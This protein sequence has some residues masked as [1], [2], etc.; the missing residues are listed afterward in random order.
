MSLEGVPKATCKPAARPDRLGARDPGPSKPR[1]ASRSPIVPLMA[2]PTLVD[3]PT[4]TQT[5]SQTGS[6]LTLEHL[7]SAFLFQSVLPS[8]RVESPTPCSPLDCS[9]DRP[10]DVP[11]AWGPAL[12]RDLAQSSVVNISKSFV[13][14]DRPPPCSHLA[15]GAP[16]RVSV[17]LG[18]PFLSPGSPQGRLPSFLHEVLRNR[19][20]PG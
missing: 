14:V 9:P 1:P 15:T 2:D 20:S 13:I 5:S 12:R 6:V 16:Q 3:S 8:R 10:K 7:I 18:Q 4:N 11:R 19:C 17:L